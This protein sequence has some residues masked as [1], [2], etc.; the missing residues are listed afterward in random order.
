MTQKACS[1]SRKQ[2]RNPS[3]HRLALTKNHPTSDSLWL[4]NLQYQSKHKCKPWRT[5]SIL[6]NM[7]SSLIFLIYIYIYISKI[8]I[9]IGLIFLVEPQHYLP[10]EIAWTWRLCIGAMQHDSWLERPWL[11]NLSSCFAAQDKQSQVKIQV[12]AQEFKTIM[13]WK[14]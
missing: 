7:A 14:T 8:Y 3:Q 9:F 1:T 5:P 13:H 11:V 6:R 4:Q 2:R 10:L 12:Q